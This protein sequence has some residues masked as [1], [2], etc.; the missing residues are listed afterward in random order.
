MKYNDS[1]HFRRGSPIRFENLTCHCCRLTV[2]RMNDYPPVGDVDNLVLGLFDYHVQPLAQVGGQHMH[3]AEARN[4]F[5]LVHVELRYAAEEQKLN[6]YNAEC[7]PSGR[8]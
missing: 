3:Q 6:L 8:K 4:E 2:I 5:V 1:D 7:H